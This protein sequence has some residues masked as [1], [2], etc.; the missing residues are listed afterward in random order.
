MP[1]FKEDLTDPLRAGFFVSP[2]QKPLGTKTT[3]VLVVGRAC[4]RE[5][6]DRESAC[7]LFRHV[8]AV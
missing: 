3:T 5:V 1:T 7:A 2:S 6:P 4:R 8:V